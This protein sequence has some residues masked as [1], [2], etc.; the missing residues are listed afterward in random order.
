MKPIPHAGSMNPLGSPGTPAP[1]LYRILA[2]L[3]AM[4]VACS[5]A[6]TEDPAAGQAHTINAAVALHAEQSDQSWSFNA[7]ASWYLVPDS[8]DY[9]Q[10]TFTAD[11]HWL[12]L[13][14]RYN[15]EDLETGSAW[16][17]YNFCGGDKLAWELTSMLG[18]V[19]GDTTGMA[20]GYKGSL[21]WW[22]LALY[23][24]GEYVWDVGDSSDSFFYNWSEL[25][26]WPVDWLRIGIVTQRTR[27][28]ASDREIQRGILAGVAYKSVEFATYVF[29]PDDNTPILTVAFGV[30]F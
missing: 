22:K 6:D 5:A 13:E 27:A 18:G 14:T 29:N 28:Y 15:Y 24:E 7:S 2:A 21:M 16:V 19:Y 20:P 10:P 25:S 11:R 17:G 26:L 9:I 3:T 30:K 23:S 1:I 8:R 4:Q 12:H